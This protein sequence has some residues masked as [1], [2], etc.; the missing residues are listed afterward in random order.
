MNL[1][2][3]SLRFLILTTIVLGIIYPFS[4]LFIGQVI[5]PR[6][7]QGSLESKDGV[8]I[9]SHFI[10]QKFS[11]DE[12]FWPRPSSV[13]FNASSSGASQKSLTNKTLQEKYLIERKK[14]G[15][16][17]PIDLISASGSG[18][19]P[20]ISVDAA[21]YQKERVRLKRHMSVEEI[22]ALIKK[23]TDDRFLGF[24]GQPRV[25][26]LELNLLLDKTQG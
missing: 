9:G 7:S 13:D 6:M 12:Y 26:V 21:H 5:F 3:T 19:D 18:L 14:L 25:N 23:A 1:V 11:R 8:I 4:V 10:A 15:D 22:D 2:I 20:H 17:A 16:D 24:M